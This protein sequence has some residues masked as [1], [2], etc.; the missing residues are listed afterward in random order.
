M[1]A[2]LIGPKPPQPETP[3]YPTPWIVNPDD[4]TE[5][6]DANGCSLGRMYYIDLA[7]AV[8][9]IVNASAGEPKPKRKLAYLVDD[10]DDKWFELRPGRFTYGRNVADAT[11]ALADGSSYTDWSREKLGARYD[12]IREVYE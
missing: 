8:K 11:R 10:Y 9:D 12:S 5:L 4:D 6:I 1:T 7:A 3:R 2:E